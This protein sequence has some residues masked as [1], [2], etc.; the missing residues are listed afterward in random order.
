MSEVVRC[1]RCPKE[2]IR[3]YRRLDESQRPDAMKAYYEFIGIS[4]EASEDADHGDFCSWRCLAEWAA[5]MADRAATQEGTS[6]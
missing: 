6:E 4:V 1:D 3:S 2:A 5:D